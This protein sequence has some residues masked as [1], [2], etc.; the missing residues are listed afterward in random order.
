[1]SNLYEKEQRCLQKWLEGVP[2]DGDEPDP[3]SED[4]ERSDPNFNPVQERCSSD[5]SENKT[6]L[7]QALLI[8]KNLL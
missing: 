5:E 6:R 1:M 3:F 7:N 4:S 2:S 8:G